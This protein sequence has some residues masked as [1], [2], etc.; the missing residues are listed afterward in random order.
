MAR[1]FGVGLLAV[2]L[3]TWLARDPADSA[4][5]LAIARAFTVS[6]GIGVVWPC[7][8]R[9]PARSTPWAGSRWD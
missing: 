7:G 6:Y 1:W 4:G 8:G 9:W 2:G 5:G 3:T